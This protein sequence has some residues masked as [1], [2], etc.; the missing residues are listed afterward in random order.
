VRRLARSLRL[1][2]LALAARLPA[3]SFAACLPALALAACLPALAL[4]ACRPERSA[5]P[6]ARAV[7]E[8]LPARP[9]QGRLYGAMPF[10]PFSAPPGEVPA[11]GGGQR[12]ALAPAVEPAAGSGRS[13]A[14]R[15]DRLADQAELA[16]AQGLVEPAIAN[17][18]PALALAPDSVRLRN[19]AAVAFLERGRRLGAPFD[20]LAALRHAL[21][22]TA[23]APDSAAAQ[24]NLGLALEALFLRHQAQRAWERYLELDPAGE[25]AGEVRLRLRRLAVRPFQQGWERWRALLRRREPVTAA[26]LA[27]LVRGYP[28]QVREL[29]V[30]ELLPAAAVELAAEEARTGQA[31]TPTAREAGPGQAS[32][33]A[34]QEER[35]GQVD[36]VAAQ[37]AGPGQA[38]AL[39][40]AIA[41]EMASQRGD[42][43][44]SDSWRALGGA[45]PPAPA[46]VEAHRQLALGMSRYH[47]QEFRA[48]ES[49]LGQAIPALRAAASPLAGEAELYRAICLY[50]EHAGQARPLLAALLAATD[51]RRFPSLAG[52]TLWMLGT[53][54]MV[55]ERHEE[56]LAQFGEMRELLLRGAGEDQA[57]I[58]DSAL[59]DD[60]E[61]RGEV[62]RGWIHR[63]RALR[64]LIPR[65]DA[66][67]RHSILF[68]SAQ[69]LARR[70]QLDLALAFLDEV[71]DNAPEWGEPIARAEPYA[72]RARV[73][74]ELGET[75]GAVADAELALAAVAAMP[76]GGLRRRVQGVALVSRGA[77]L[78]A[79]DPA[80]AA[81]DLGDG[82][83]LERATGWLN[84]RT[85][86]LTSLAAA[87]LAR[88]DLPAARKLLVEAVQSYER[89]RREAMKTEARIAIFEHAQSAFDALIGLALAG[90]DPGRAE[91]FGWAERSRSRYLAD[92]WTARRTVPGRAPT[93]EARELL[94]LLPA[95]TTLLEFAVLREQTVVWVAADGGLRSALLPLGNAELTRQVEDFRRAVESGSADARLLGAALFDRLLRPLGLGGSAGR[96]LVI[97]PD[98]PLQRAPFAALYDRE[99]GEYLIE[100][101]IL[102]VA[103]SATVV[104]ALVARGLPEAR[105]P[106]GEEALVVGAPVLADTGHAYLGD[107]PGSAAEAR[108]I[109]GLYPGSV[110]LL[111]REANRE[112]FLSAL[113]RCRVL[114]FAG[115]ALAV[116]SGGDSSLLLLTP[117]APG[118]GGEVSA[119]QLRGLALPRLELVVLAACRSAAGYSPGREG[120]LSLAS[121][122]LAAGAPSVVAASGP[123]DDRTSPRL[124]H[125]FH[126][127]VASGTD[128]PA[129]LRQV[130]LECLHSR[131][132]VLSAPSAWAVF[133]AFGI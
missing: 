71:I 84:D 32:A 93:V 36:R 132:P 78:L 8:R 121:A 48:A 102:T 107:L 10:R 97:V 128:P 23:L 65:G 37:Q 3:R 34:A 1:P 21:R 54:A 72:V 51:R 108:E 19:D 4:A 68:E 92:S 105:S 57:A 77:A 87:H 52:R 40:A 88:G 122:F 20:L 73:R 103:P 67:R 13:G 46:L 12:G 101:A 2:A 43:L 112:R 66:R 47:A 33:L 81:Q 96:R 7:L 115:H 60:Y 82:A 17:L 126:A 30:E 80:R 90:G 14:E 63:L 24:F 83:T 26:A 56:A 39:A 98:G 119:A 61:L 85:L 53:I 95:G 99:R 76:P 106:G 58:A 49:Q 110:L 6:T 75:D 27:E 38:S 89:T 114:H 91:A 133:T 127:L 118:D 45:R 69:A 28:H 79:A 22:A 44:L 86:V 120:A 131:D 109:A 35:S 113:Q 5:A 117:A 100:Q 130:M 16:L 41:G 129:A 74:A 124:M 125:R 104:A 15:S 123:V 18:A 62:E 42:W 116:E 59:G 25:W 64:V 29:M 111:G 70:H 55:Q 31:N 9:F 50:Y 11:A 94:P